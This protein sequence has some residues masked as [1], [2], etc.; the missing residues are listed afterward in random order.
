MAK[1]MKDYQIFK[2]PY[3]YC[4]Y[5]DESAKSNTSVGNPVMECP[6]CGKKLYR[7]STFEP[8]LINGKRFFDIK[9]SSLYKGLRTALVVILVVS[10]AVMLII[11]DF[12]VATSLLALSMLLYVLYEALRMV[13]R[14]TY[15]KSNDYDM[16]I[17]RSLTRLED[18]DYAKTIIRVQGVE[19]GSVYY[20]E[21]YGEE[22]DL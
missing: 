7:N 6:A 14:N 8:A 15:L 3:C 12:H 16:E 20:Y 13:H 4:E 18:E 9:F 22:V 11:R 21:M 17:N 2:C 10:V 1:K 19:E 5:Y